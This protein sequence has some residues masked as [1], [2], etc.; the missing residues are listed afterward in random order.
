MPVF[1]GAKDWTTKMQQVEEGR[2]QEEFN[3]ALLES[4]KLLV[5]RLKKNQDSRQREAGTTAEGITT[6]EL[7]GGGKGEVDPLLRPGEMARQEL[8]W[9]LGHLIV[10]T[11]RDASRRAQQKRCERWTKRKTQTVIVTE[12]FAK[13]IFKRRHLTK[14]PH[15]AC[16]AYGFCSSLH[17]DATKNAQRPV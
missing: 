8:T 10:V 15:T 11:H 1:V 4:V 14:R 9:R 7:E 16:F 12:N 6:R 17:G 3:M 13:H 5:E 2:E